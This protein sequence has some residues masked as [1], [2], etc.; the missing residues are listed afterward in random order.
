MLIS[1]RRNK[2]LKT[3]LVLYQ[4]LKYYFNPVPVKILCLL[5]C[6]AGLMSCEE[7]QQGCM[8]ATATNFKVS[9]Q[10]PCCC[11]YPQIVFQTTLTDGDETASFADTFSNQSG[12]NY[13]I[14]D[15]RFIASDITLT[16][17]L[18]NVY[19]PV[20]TF[21]K[22]H[23]SPD[24]LAADVL[25]LNST[26]ANFMKDGIYN[27]LNFNIEQVDALKD[28]LPRNFPM[29]HPFR[30]SSFYD[31]SQNNWIFM[32]ASINVLGRGT[33]SL[34]ILNED[35]SIPV[36]LTGEWRKDRGQDLIVNFRINVRTLFNTVDFSLPQEEVLSVFKTN[37]PDSF[38]P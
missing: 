19:H 17:S 15:L 5:G 27:R 20:D 18:D 37:L 24:L 34:D 4:Q 7:Y 16:D 1:W 26:G 3:A 6:F 21:E 9:N 31:F 29:E 2:K 25:E 14:N 35:L 23:V 10:S 30:D 36:S 11:E 8:D 32:S 22:Y 28:E 33:V 12:Q 38:E 13:L